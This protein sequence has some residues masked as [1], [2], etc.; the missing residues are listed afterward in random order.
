M[1]IYHTAWDLSELR[2]IETD[3]TAVPAWAFFAR[4]IVAS[5]L[6]LVGIGLVLAHGA[7]FRAR[8]FLRRLGW[9][10]LAAGAITAVTAIAFP[11]SYIFFG[12]LHAIALSSLLAL[13]F[14]RAPA[15]LTGA[16][17]LFVMAAPFA[18]AGPAFDT[19]KLAFLGLGTRLPVTNDFVPVFPWTGFVLAGVA[20]APVARRILGGQARSGGFA[21]GLAWVGRHS[22][23]IYLLHQP[24]IF[25]TLSGVA[26]LAGPSEAAVAAPYMR[27]CTATCEVAGQPA[28]LCRASCACTIDRLKA[29]GLWVTALGGR[30]DA[31][32][33]ERMSDAARLCYEQA[34]RS[35]PATPSPR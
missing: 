20:A 6:I 15:A 34:R 21:R 19:P 13:P 23:A 5:F 27:R 9:I 17:A 7:G 18:I 35:A 28:A 25:G 29:G 16:V 10:A 32:E 30:S 1:A 14:L 4:A 24:I 31:A 2:L 11:A 12:I 8:A 3:V 33:I 22:L 26:A